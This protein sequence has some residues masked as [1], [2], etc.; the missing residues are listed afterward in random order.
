VVNGRDKLLKSK[1]AGLIILGV[2]PASSGKRFPSTF[3]IRK[4]QALFLSFRDNYIS[5]ALKKV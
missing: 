1:T 3:Y 4:K 5:K 2:N